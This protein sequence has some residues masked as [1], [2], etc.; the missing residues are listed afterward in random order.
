MHSPPRLTGL[1]V[2]D[3]APQAWHFLCKYVF[4]EEGEVRD[5]LF[6]LILP[7]SACGGGGGGGGSA[8]D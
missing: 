4:L 3:S 7:V 1:N 6:S 8:N 2:V 5:N